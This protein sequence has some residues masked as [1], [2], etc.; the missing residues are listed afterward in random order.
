MQT[1]IDDKTGKFFPPPV[2]EVY[3]DFRPSMAEQMGLVGHILELMV[4]VEAGVA[5]EEA[6]VAADSSDA[7]V[8]ASVSVLATRLASVWGIERDLR[9]RDKQHLDFDVWVVEVLARVDGIV[10]DD[11]CDTCKW[12]TVDKDDERT[13]SCSS[14]DD[15]NKVGGPRVLDLDDPDNERI[16]CPF[17]EEAEHDAT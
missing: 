14:D 6:R 11:R 10:P 2:G 9:V 1:Y 13:G 15:D 7:S 3:A 12:C 8:L 17:Y 4:A 16:R 5:D